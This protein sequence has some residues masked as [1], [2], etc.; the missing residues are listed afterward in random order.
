MTDSENPS[1]CSGTRVNWF[2]K[3]FDYKIAHPVT[4]IY[5]VSPQ[6][7]GAQVKHQ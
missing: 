1:R 7:G 3:L 6:P 5:G 2:N 4:E